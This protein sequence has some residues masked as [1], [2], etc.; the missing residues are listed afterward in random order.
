MIRTVG[1]PVL[2]RRLEAAGWRQ[3]RSKGSHRQV[4]HPSRPGVITVPH[5]RED[6]G[7]GLVRAILE[8]AGLK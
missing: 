4:A 1:S 2:I 8:H 6:L 7:A 3:V 5:P